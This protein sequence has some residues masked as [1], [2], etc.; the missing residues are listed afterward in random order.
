MPPAEDV[1][2]QAASPGR[3]VSGCITGS[4]S[5]GS[6]YELCL[7]EGGNPTETLILYAHGFVF[8]Q[9]PIALP[10]DDDFQS[11]FL[12]QCFAYGTTSFDTN[13]L[14]N[15]KTATKEL[16]ELI[17]LH[18]RNYG[19]PDHVLLFG[20]S[21]GALLSTLA[22]EQHPGLFDGGLAV[23]GPVG[24]YVRNVEY[25]GDIYVVFDTLFPNALDNFFGVEAGG[26]EGISPDFLQALLRRLP[27]RT[28]R[29]AASSEASCRP[30]SSIPR[31]PPRRKNC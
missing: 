10:E 3:N 26:P 28:S 22:I 2:S 11:F 6:L 14:V 5:S 9:L 31:M 13:G 30:S 17:T 1:R 21:N 18:T 25:L 24:S 4:Q 27:M 16:R 29:H 8:P 23:C 19:R 20:V 15:P 12:S 7:P